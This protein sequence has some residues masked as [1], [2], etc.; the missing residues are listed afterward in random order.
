MGEH[1]E[2]FFESQKEASEKAIKALS[3]QIDQLTQKI[4]A[5]QNRLETIK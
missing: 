1:E 2:K 3:L 4:E 5:H